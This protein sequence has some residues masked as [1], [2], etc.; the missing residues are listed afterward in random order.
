ME[1]E[2][3]TLYLQK[4]YGSQT[5]SGTSYGFTFN[6]NK[7]FN[8]SMQK[9]PDF[10]KGY[11]AMANIIH[12]DKNIN[13]NNKIGLDMG[14]LV[15]SKELPLM[16][17]LLFKFEVPYDSEECFYQ[18][19][20]LQKIV[21]ALQDVITDK[22]DIDEHC[23]QLICCVLESSHWQ[24]KETTNLRLKFQFPYCRIDETYN[25]TVLK[26]AI[27][28]AFR[29]YK[30]ISLME[31]TPIGDISG[32]LIN[33]GSI[34]P[35][36]GSKSDYFEMPLQLTHIYGIISGKEI[37]ELELND[38]VFKPLN[39]SFI[40]N[41]S[42]SSSFIN[43]ETLEEYD[44]WIPLFLSI[45]YWSGI[46]S[47]KEND[48]EKVKSANLYINEENDKDPK[49]LANI[50]LKMLNPDKF[51]REDLWLT[52]GQVLYNIY[53]ADIEG[54]NTWTKFS[55]SKAGSC[56]SIYHSF[57]HN[58][59][60]EKTLAFYA[61]IDS[62]EEYKD[63]HTEWCKPA[64]R[65]A[66]TL[67]VADC[68]E[69]IYRVFWLDYITTGD[70]KNSWYYYSKNYYRQL[71][72]MINFRKEINDIFILI[73]KR[74]SADASE[75]RVSSNNKTQKTGDKFSEKELS[76]FIQQI[77]NLI[78]KLKN[79]TFVNS[80]LEM[81][82][83]RFYD[84]NFAKLK[85]TNVDMMGWA[86]GITQCCGPKIFFRDGKPQDYITMN[87]GTP[88]KMEYN[89]KHK[90]VIKLMEWLIRVFP[91]NLDRYI[92][93]DFENPNNKNTFDHV[94]YFLKDS[95]TF[96]YGKN[97]EKAFRI[98]LGGTNASKSI[99]N[100]LFELTFGFQYC[101]AAP[102]SQI[103]K[104]F[105]TG[106]SGPSPDVAQFKGARSAFYKEPDAED[107]LV[108]GKIKS[109]S[110][111]D[112][113]FARGC[114]ENGGRIEAT[115]KPVL[116]T[117]IFPRVRNLDEAARNR[118]HIQRYLAR[119]CD[120]A[121]T[122][123]DEQFRTKRFKNDPFF[124]ADLP[125]LAIAFAWVLMQFYPIYKTEG[126]KPPQN[127]VEFLNKHWEDTDDYNKFI[128]QRLY[129]DD[130]EDSIFNVQDLYCHFVKWYKDNNPGKDRDIPE[131][132]LFKERMIEVTRLG[133][134]NEYD[135]WTGYKILK[136]GEKMPKQADIY[137]V[138]IDNCIEHDY[139]T[140]GEINIHSLINEYEIYPHFVGWVKTN[141][142][143]KNYIIPTMEAF[144]AIMAHSDYLN[145]Q[146]EQGNWRG[147]RLVV[148]A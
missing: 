13:E 40:K 38:E 134:L 77:E 10:L 118:F 47:P 135:E 49:T 104:V 110:G 23:S 52:V 65:D 74:L 127:Y 56:H 44:M 68:T 57:R 72:K 1:E 113:K 43:I 141:D 71:K 136:A 108:A 51:S 92:E 85:D 75:R 46:T 53:D 95:S 124:E 24:D 105:K 132:N 63:W 5:Q 144:K 25:K 12:L 122:S 100:K 121:P 147:I 111:G 45:H 133:P 22:L 62:P 116:V 143:Y 112:S 15:S 58:H 81:C 67:N 90:D 148:T 114:N 2:K 120:N 30:I 131:S 37:E 93:F 98:W 139:N 8:V 145:K 54:Y 99:I 7:T 94:Y 103:C 50:F 117:N 14:E 21:E 41:E 80:V 17:N 109:E 96:L 20:F 86:N 129:R 3:T 123:I 34:I 4:K 106:S 48:E 119:F 55:K 16:V 83:I 28:S 84:D 89:W 140:H 70:G 138:Y 66:L 35:L 102:L 64:L 11:C 27:I 36:Y 6:S 18:E 115:H 59:Y 60:D 128:K 78:K 61:R 87:T 142:K 88:I 9:M 125:D 126:L 26:P 33:N 79:P 130:G 82:E 97:A 146:D 31:H 137:R 101:I 91:G 39:F 42:I 107:E 73:Y 32:A 76:N 19:T 29:R 69:A